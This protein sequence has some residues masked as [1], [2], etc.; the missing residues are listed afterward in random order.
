M[1]YLYVN[2]FNPEESRNVPVPEDLENWIKVKIDPNEN[3][4]G[5]IY[6]IATGL[7]EDD[8]RKKRALS[9]SLMEEDLNTLTIKY[10]NNIFDADVNS[11][12][13]LVAA[14]EAMEDNM[15]IDWVLTNNTLVK[16][17]RKDLRAVLLLIVEK[18]TELVVKKNDN[19]KR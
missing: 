3:I 15:V 17:T 12:N 5:K 8:E 10:K 9:R 4:I 18:H 1:K 2:K 11:K 13:A 19:K 7:F 14:I 16:L 6:N